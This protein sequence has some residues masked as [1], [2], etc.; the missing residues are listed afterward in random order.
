MCLPNATRVTW[1]S[2]TLVAF[3]TNPQSYY[4]GTRMAAAPV[5]YEEAIQISKFLSSGKP[6]F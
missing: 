2:F 1:D 4:P 5:S 3:I 6:P